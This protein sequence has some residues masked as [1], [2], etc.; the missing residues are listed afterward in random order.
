VHHARG[1]LLH[2]VILQQILQLAGISPDTT[3]GS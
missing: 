3:T 1:D 2:C